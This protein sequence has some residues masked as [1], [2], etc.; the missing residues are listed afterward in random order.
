MIIGVPSEIKQDEY[1]V[2]MIPVGIEELVR[3]GHQVLV[4]AGAGLGSGIPDEDYAGQGAEITG[5]PDE[6]FARADMIVLWWV[7]TPC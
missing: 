1:R 2:S 5:G 3:S 4:Q 7:K 6:I